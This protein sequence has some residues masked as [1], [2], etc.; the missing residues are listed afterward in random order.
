MTKQLHISEDLALPIEFVTQTQA[1]LARKR[2][3]KSYTASVQAE[4]MLR[5]QQQVLVIDYTGAWWGLRA[6]ANGKAEGGYPIR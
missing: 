1:I 5:L 6:G 2:V 4:E 3:G